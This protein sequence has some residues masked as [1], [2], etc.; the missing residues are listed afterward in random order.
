MNVLIISVYPPDPAPEANHAL[1][2]S[3]QLARLGHTVHVL[4][5]KGSIAAPQPGIVVHPD[6]TDWS[7]PDLPT[8]VACLRKYRPDVVLLVYIGWVYRHHPMITFI[9]TICK[10]MRPQIPCVTQFEIV[11]IG[12]PTPSLSTRALR[13]AMTLWAGTK[14]LNWTLGT[15]LRDS[16]HT[17]VLSSPHRDRLSAHN[18]DVTEK[19]VISPP[20]PLIRVSQD[21]PHLVRQRIR[22]R[23]GAAADDFVLIYWGYIYPGKGIETLLQAFRSVSRR[24]K[25]VRLVLVGGKLEILDRRQEC[26]DYFDMLHRLTDELGLADRVT[27]TGHFNWDDDAGSQYLHGGDVCV[28][29]FDYGVTLNNSSLA[30][31]STHGLPVISTEL[32]KGRDEALDH[33]RHIYLCP[34][35]DPDLL[36]EAIQLIRNNTPLRER[37]RSGAQDLARQWYTWD[38][39]AQRLA[40]VLLSAVSSTG[41]AA[42][43]PAHRLAAP[44]HK[45]TA[46]DHSPSNESGNDRPEPPPVLDT[47]RPSSHETTVTPLISIVVAVHNVDRYLSQCLDALVNQTLR[48]IEIIVVNDAST[49]RSA[50]IIQDYQ[51]VYPT[52]NVITCSSNKG[53]ASVRNIGLRA[54]RGHYVAFADGDDWVDVRMCEVLYRRARTDGAEVVIADTTVFYEDTKRF[55]LFFDQTIRQSLD[56]RLRKAPFGLTSEPRT[57]LL[58]PVAWT[59]LYDREFLR[60]HAIEFEDGM[61]SYEDICFH[62]SVLLK[63][64]RISLIDDRLFFYRQNRPGQISG[65][66]SRK[67]FEIFDVFTRIHE[68]LTAWNAPPNIW[69][70]LAKIQVRQFNWLLK[71][72]VDAHHKR[73]FLA[74]VAQQFETIPNAG[75][76]TFIQHATPYELATALCMRRNW[77]AAYEHISVNC[78]AWLSV[79]SLWQRE[80]LPSVIKKLLHLCRE[81]LRGRIATLVR[82]VLNT[83]FRGHAVDHTHTH[84]V[85]AAGDRS[86]NDPNGSGAPLVEVA[87]ID[88]HVLFLSRYANSGLGDAIWRIRNDYYLLQSAVFRTGDTAIDIGAHVGA[89]SIYLAKKFPFIT[90][91]A[92][93]PNPQS[94]ACL[95]RN[96]ELN[97]VTNIIAINKA[98][99][100][101]G[102]K[103]T[104]YTNTAD[105][106]WATIDA[107]SASACYLLSTAEVETITLE[108]VFQHYRIGHCRL[109]KITAP[110]AVQESLN[111]FTRTGQID[112]LCG[113]V[114]FGECNR[115]QLET[116]C[117]KIAR[118]HFWRTISHHGHNTKHHWIHEIPSWIEQ[119]QLK[120]APC[121]DRA[122]LEPTVAPSETTRT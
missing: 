14:E 95:Q 47:R 84:P 49:D 48:N 62:F 10:A 63:A 39:T 5:K 53:L 43:S 1:H 76:H 26:A 28:L 34:P 21:P 31:A 109:L 94:F 111:S 15:L 97:G 66:R 17:I 44:T 6:I 74:R 117:W 67:T 78:W 102:T 51:S 107:K 86:H 85:Q 59:K 118:H 91:Y 22:T 87:R 77:L 92:L 96:I 61:N 114:D 57:L 65:R 122:M 38:T 80:K 101:D 120:S 58:E 79:L 83:I 33:G 55:G 54:A 30:A 113:E 16:T 36:A 24:D 64:K 70:I 73:E 46:I 108:Q 41:K 105:N 72:R 110:G 25:T 3:E 119:A 75:L 18:A 9:P 99:S 82:P 20:P 68:N 88:D 106:S 81:K 42:P 12:G 60:K 37:L 112:L 69:A 52:L 90:I 23:I 2:M 35:R 27:W 89:T 32:A 7:W 104:L 29:P 56:A 45:S 4:C 71:D 103:R 100:A 19:T 98:L 93:E 8:I 11:D 13:K 50:K 115:V 121:P 40:S 116:A